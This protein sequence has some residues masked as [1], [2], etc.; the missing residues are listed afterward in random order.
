MTGAA[1]TGARGHDAEIFAR[2]RKALDARPSIPATVRVHVDGGTAT[3]TGT[4]RLASEL[5]EAEDV[6]R[7]VAGVQRVINELAVAV[8]PSTEGFE[9]PAA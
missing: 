5:A 3:L 4:V 2:V 6:V 9:P 8:P 1:A 7:H